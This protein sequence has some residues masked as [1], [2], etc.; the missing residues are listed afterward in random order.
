MAAPSP[1]DS[2]H[3]LAEQGRAPP[4][5]HHH[6]FT[7]PKVTATVIKRLSRRK[8]NLT[9]NT[10]HEYLGWSGTRQPYHEYVHQ[11]VLA[12]WDSLHELD[13]YMT[14]DVEDQELVISVLD[15]TDSHELVH[16]PDIHDRT[17]LGEFLNADNREGVR[18]RLYM[19]EQC[20]S[21][22]A[23][24]MEAFGHSL[25]LDP[26]FFQW[27]I[28]GKHGV[29]PLTPSERHRAPFMSIGFGVP[30]EQTASR[31]DAQYFRVSMY[32]QRDKSGEGWTG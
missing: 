2:S 21:L 1:T 12:G 13:N 28:R 32:I 30:I 20:G 15:I 10:L 27:S 25:G 22:S 16:H 11:L 9:S 23:G 8:R 26:R 29:A 31:T 3:S 18:V 7:L 19:A 6:D 14:T 5:T 17:V 24:V 4:P